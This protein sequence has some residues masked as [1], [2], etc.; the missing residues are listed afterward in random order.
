MPV[1]E[2]KLCGKSVSKRES[3]EYCSK[4]C[5]GNAQKAGITRH[6]KVI[7]SKAKCKHCGSEFTLK[8]RKCGSYKGWFC[9]QSCSNLHQ[10]AGR[11]KK[12]QG[13]D[14]RNVDRIKKLARAGGIELKCVVCGF[15][16]AIDGAHLVPASRGGR[17]DESNRIWLCPNH[18]RLF[19]ERL[20][21]ES[22]VEKLPK[23]AQD[24]YNDESLKP[25]IPLHRFQELRSSGGQAELWSRASEAAALSD[26]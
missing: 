1:I 15:D 5:Y 24:V 22:E 21:Y 14:R 6:K 23:K 11:T 17:H 8:R 9:S 13:G 19:D 7:K 20:L 18:H 10:G 3:G 25:K 26:D 16:R 2:C 12:H 4:K